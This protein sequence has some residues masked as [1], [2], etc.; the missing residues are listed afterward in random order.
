[1]DIWEP[2]KVPN[3]RAEFRFR[4]LELL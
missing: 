3:V 2:S 1:V 4:I